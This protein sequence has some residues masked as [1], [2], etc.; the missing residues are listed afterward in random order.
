MVARLQRAKNLILT[1]YR[2]YMVGQEHMIALALNEAE[3]LAWQT[4]FPLLVFPTLAFEKA[5]SVASW[6]GRQRKLRTQTARITD[7]SLAP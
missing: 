7:L 6:Q 5:A 4:D 2:N 1:E 3:A